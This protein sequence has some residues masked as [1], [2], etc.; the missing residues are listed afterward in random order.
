MTSQTSS[1]RK[2]RKSV[3]FS[4][5]TDCANLWVKLTFSAVC[6]TTFKVFKASAAASQDSVV[7]TLL[8]I[9]L[10][11]AIASASPFLSGSLAIAS[12]SIPYPN[13]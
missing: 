10:A 4:S 9:A 5:T 6:N 11:C 12:Y 7:Y 3:S 1:L 2:E 13:S 8:S